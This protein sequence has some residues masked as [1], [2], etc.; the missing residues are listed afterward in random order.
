[1]SLAIWDLVTGKQIRQFG[2]LDSNILS[3]AF[4]PD[5]RKLA[6]GFRNGDLLI[7]D[8]TALGIEQKAH[9]R[10]Y[11]PQEM[12]QWWSALALD[13]PAGYRASWELADA[14]AQ[15]IPFLSGRLR[16]VRQPD[17]ADISPAQIHFPPPGDRLQRLRAVSVLER[18]GTPQAEQILETLAAGSPLAGQTLYA[19]AALN[20]LRSQSHVQKT[21][22]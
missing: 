16:R 17:P 19:Q 20:R 1:M 13:S 12:E 11:T 10:T 15:A 4:A 8:L 18:I 7:W 22:K 9:A 21:T 3:L 5:G 6:T 2:P 14:A